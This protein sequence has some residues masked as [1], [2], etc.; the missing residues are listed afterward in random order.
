MP[1]KN[2]GSAKSECAAAVLAGITGPRTALI[3]AIEVARASATVPISA[4]LSKLARR[5]AQGID[6]RPSGTAA[7]RIGF[8][9]F[10]GGTRR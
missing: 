4:V 10:A 8:R 6:H 7:L 9:E 2:G 1:V 3:S 5:G